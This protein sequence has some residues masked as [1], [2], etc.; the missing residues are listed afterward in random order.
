MSDLS[1]QRAEVESKL[2][3]A[4]AVWLTISEELEMVEA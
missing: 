1:K 4:E 3:A 2:E